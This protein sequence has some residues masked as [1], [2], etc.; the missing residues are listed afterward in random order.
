MESLV[1]NHGN[2]LML[3]GNAMAGVF[4]ELFDMEMTVA[5]LE[6]GTCGRQ[7]EVGS[8]WAFVETPGYVLRCPACQE[9]VMRLTITPSRVYL[10]ARGAAYLCLP[11]R[12]N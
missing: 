9:V 3:D 12:S 2:S 11:K 10:E 8:L 6:C 1:E 4:Y 5:W 7:G